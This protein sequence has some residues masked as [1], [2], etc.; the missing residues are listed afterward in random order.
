MLE[1][2]SIAV[3]IFEG[4][5]LAIPVGIFGF[6]W[7]DAECLE[8]LDRGGPLVEGGQIEYEKMFVSRR[9]FNGDAVLM[10]EFDVPRTV[11]PSD[12]DAVET[13]VIVEARQHLEA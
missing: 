5:A 6:A 2:D 8:P 3:R 7:R 12:D 11:A 9:A 10:R 4:F 1:D 13:L